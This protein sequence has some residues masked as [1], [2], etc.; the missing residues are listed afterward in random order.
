M[1]ILVSVLCSEKDCIYCYL[2]QKMCV[3]SKRF[4]GKRTKESKNRASTRS[5]RDERETRHI[6]RRR[7]RRGMYVCS[8]RLG[9][10]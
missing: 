2:L 7:K 10:R 5:E 4:S 3:E 1:D 8:N 9:V 6:E